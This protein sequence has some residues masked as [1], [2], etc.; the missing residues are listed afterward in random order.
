MNLR[1]KTANHPARTDLC[2]DLRDLGLAE[3]GHRPVA[4]EAADVT[5]EIL[6]EPSTV[7]GVDHFGVELHR[8]DAALVVG[9]H[10]ERRA[11]AGGDAAETGGKLRHL[12]AVAHPHL[13]GLA[14]SPQPVEQRAGI[15]DFDEGA[16]EFARI[17][18]QN[19]TSQ[20]VHQRLLA[21]AD[22]HDRQAAVEDLGRDARAFGIEHRGGRA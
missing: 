10:R 2:A 15:G 11:G 22:R 7:G 14:F 5:D 4:D 1:G 12:V 3:F 16:S 8:I 21:I 9:D 19:L 18:G 20:L 13:M 6:V 17:A